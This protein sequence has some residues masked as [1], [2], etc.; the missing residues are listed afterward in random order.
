LKLN[1]IQNINNN[2]KTDIKN[3]NSTQDLIEV[4]NFNIENFSNVNEKIKIDVDSSYE[5]VVA[6]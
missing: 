6:S 4:N 2:S 1:K 5:S 3:E